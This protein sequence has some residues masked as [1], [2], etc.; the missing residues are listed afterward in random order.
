MDGDAIATLIHDVF[1]RGIRDI[2]DGQSADAF[3][4]TIVLIQTALGQ[5]TV[6]ETGGHSTSAAALTK[7]STERCAHCFIKFFLRAT[8]RFDL[9]QNFSN[10]GFNLDQVIGIALGFN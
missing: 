2:S 8:F 3:E 10:R 7:Q 4:V 6:R 9:L 5:P 1:L